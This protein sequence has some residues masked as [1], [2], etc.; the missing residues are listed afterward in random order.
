MKALGKVLL[1]PPSL[2]MQT[3]ASQPVFLS[4]AAIFCS[5]KIPPGLVVIWETSRLE[6]LDKKEKDRE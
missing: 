2:Q 1:L 4:P 3:E 5:G 6:K